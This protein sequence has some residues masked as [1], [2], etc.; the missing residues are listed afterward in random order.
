MDTKLSRHRSNPNSIACKHYLT[1]DTASAI[2]LISTAQK[3]IGAGARGEALK[4]GVLG[5]A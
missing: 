4:V 1:G 5:I 3:A 2:R